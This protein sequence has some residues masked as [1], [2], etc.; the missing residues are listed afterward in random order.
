[1]VAVPKVPNS[2]VDEICCKLT[3]ATMAHTVALTDSAGTLPI[4]LYTMGRL[5]LP[6]PCATPLSAPL[7]VVDSPDEI[8]WCMKTV[9]RA[10]RRFNQHQAIQFQVSAFRGRCGADNPRCLYNHCTGWEAMH[11]SVILLIPSI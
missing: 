2:S 3:L 8:D 4:H 10:S 1:M 9:Y 7:I 5:P 11:I 6:P